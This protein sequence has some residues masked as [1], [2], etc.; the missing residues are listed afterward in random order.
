MTQIKLSQIVKEQQFK[1]YIRESFTNTHYLLVAEAYGQLTEADGPINKNEI[2]DLLLQTIKDLKS[3]GVVDEVP[4]DI[5]LDAMTKN[6]YEGAIEENKQRL[7][8][9]A[10]VLLA[11]PGFMSLIG[12]AI[13][14]IYRKRKFSDAELAEYKKRKRQYLK[15]KRD[16]RVTDDALHHFEK[17]YLKGNVVG[18]WFK[19]VGHTLHGWL[20]TPI[21]YLIAGILWMFPPDNKRYTWTQAMNKARQATDIISA[22]VIGVIAGYGVVQSWMSS[23]GIKASSSVMQTLESLDVAENASIAID[24]IRTIDIAE[25]GLEIGED[26]V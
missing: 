24:S 23:E 6:D 2:E 14:W 19:H 7:S 21:R 12:R 16:P 4:K 9:G 18:D 3:K 5:D 13:N 1:R 25:L 22:L 10:T 20:S 26:L 8:E 17:R 11:I 15:L